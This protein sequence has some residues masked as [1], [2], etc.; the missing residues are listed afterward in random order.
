MAKVDH[1]GAR[2]FGPRG[3]EWMMPVVDELVTEG[4]VTLEAVRV[5]KYAAPADD[6]VA[7]DV[8]LRR[9]LDRAR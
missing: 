2:V 3:E 8:G 4:L 9:G 1:P 5:I 6:R 7:R